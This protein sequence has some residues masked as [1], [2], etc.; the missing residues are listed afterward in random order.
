MENTQIVTA[1]NMAASPGLLTVMF[2]DKEHAEN[3]YNF[4]L[5][6]GHAKEDI[7]LVMS[8]GT[9]ERYYPVATSYI[10]E[11]P[12]TDSTNI[13]LKDAAIGGAVGAGIVGAIAA[14]IAVGTTIM[15]PGM[16][17][18]IAGPLAAA[19]TG[20]GAGGITGSIVGALVGAG[21]P[22]SHANLYKE[23]IESGHILMSFH[24]QTNEDMA[25]LQR[26]WR[27]QGGVVIAGAG[28]LPF[29]GSI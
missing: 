16:G 29:A 10:K 28:N 13:V 9:R 8:E 15:I 11:V 17:F 14:V 23:G 7:T 25:M 20:A 26:Q 12:T 19:L 3:A 24:P 27:E 4:L 6:K 21:I 1:G 2:P 18:V 22:E 5:E